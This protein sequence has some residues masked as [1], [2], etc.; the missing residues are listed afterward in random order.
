MKQ[1]ILIL[2]ASGML[3]SALLRYFSERSDYVV[4]ATIRSDN[5]TLDPLVET[6]SFNLIRGFEAGNFEKLV[7]VFEESQPQIVINCIGI[8]KQLPI[9]QDAASSIAVNSLFPHYL[10]KLCK[11]KESRLIHVSTDCVF[12]GKTGSYTEADI[13]DAR[14]MYGLSKFM[15][16]V[17]YANTLTLR[18]SIIGHELNSSRSLVDW[19]LA[20]EGEV[21]G[22]RRAIFSGLPTIEIAR[23]IDAYVIPHKHLCGLYHLSANAI[24]KYELLKIIKEVYGKQINIIPDDTVAIDRSL[25]SSRFINETGYSP[26]SWPYLVRS[27]HEFG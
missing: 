27:M 19:F 26:K 11:S 20:Q 17:T 22:F 21:K 12:S 25:D 24:N 13:P 8:V 14:D 9:S 3:G 4:Y 15:G 6:R 5:S 23:V 2:G 7:S 10:A 16:E 18:T 1:R